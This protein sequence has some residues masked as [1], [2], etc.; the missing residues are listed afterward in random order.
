MLF[1]VLSHKIDIWRVSG[2]HRLVCMRNNERVLPSSLLFSPP[3]CSSWQNLWNMGKTGGSIRRTASSWPHFKE[4]LHFGGIK[5]GSK[6]LV[7][8]LWHQHLPSPERQVAAAHPPDWGDPKDISVGAYW[9]T[10]WRTFFLAW[11]VWTNFSPF[12]SRR[13][14]LYLLWS[15]ALIPFSGSHLGPH[16]SQW[17][18]RIIGEGWIAWNFWTNL[19]VFN[20]RRYVTINTYLYL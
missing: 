5:E 6:C 18:R 1:S 3:F 20:V 8:D 17:H 7:M 2:V 13:K 4:H 16:F 9:K 10:P 14:D 15:L 12:L 19:W 11:F